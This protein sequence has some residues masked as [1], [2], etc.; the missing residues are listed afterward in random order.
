MPTEIILR[1][2][3]SPKPLGSS[4]TK[5]VPPRMETEEGR[6]MEGWNGRGEEKGQGRR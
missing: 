6:V 3:K 2:I 5:G 1:Y 4:G